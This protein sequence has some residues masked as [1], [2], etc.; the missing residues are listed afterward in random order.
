MCTWVGTSQ[1][2]LTLSNKGGCGSNRIHF[3]FWIDGS[4]DDVSKIESESWEFSLLVVLNLLL[5]SSIWG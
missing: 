1:A 5:L 3:R 4:R 2:Q